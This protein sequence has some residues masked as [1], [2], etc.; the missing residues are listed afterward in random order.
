MTIEQAANDAIGDGDEEP[1]EEIV[2]FL[3]L[4]W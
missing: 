2:W 4:K 1:C 3:S